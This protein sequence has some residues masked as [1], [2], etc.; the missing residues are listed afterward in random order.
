MTIENGEITWQ[1]VLDTAILEADQEGV[2]FDPYSIQN[3]TENQKTMIL[4]LTSKKV[5]FV[6]W[7]DLTYHG[8]RYYAAHKAV[9]SI[10]ASAGEGTISGEGIGSVS[11]NKNQSTLNPSAEQGILETHFGRQYWE[12][13]VEN[14]ELRQTRFFVG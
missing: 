5:L 3:F 12:L 7:T 4:D 11:I 13:L 10:T 1:D 8:R 6:R 9:M 2:S 14:V